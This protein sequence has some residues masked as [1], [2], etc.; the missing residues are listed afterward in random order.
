MIRK[1]SHGGIRQNL[2]EERTNPAMA[3]AN[4]SIRWRRDEKTATSLDGMAFA[5]QC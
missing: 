4:V 2:A 1:T 3:H 5:D